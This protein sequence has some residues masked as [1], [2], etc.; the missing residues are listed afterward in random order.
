MG[1]NGTLLPA[2]C[3]AE[4][5]VLETLF[6]RRPWRQTRVSGKEEGVTPDY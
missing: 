6:R 1:N 3:S 4:A 5:F 2:P